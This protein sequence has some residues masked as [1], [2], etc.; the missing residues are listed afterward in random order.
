MNKNLSSKLDM[1]KPQPPESVNGILFGKRILADIIKDLKIRSF[2]I[3]WVGTKSNDKCPHKRHGKERQRRGPCD[4]GARDWGNEATSPEA[5]TGR[6]DPPWNRR[7]ER[8]PVTL[9]S[10]P[11]N[12]RD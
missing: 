6:K 2:R 11:H 4:N 7:R 5:G 10:G 9:T 8:G 3:T 12:V 1:S